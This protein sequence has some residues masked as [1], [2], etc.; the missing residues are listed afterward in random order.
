MVGFLNLALGISSKEW[1]GYFLYIGRYSLHS[2][3][4]EDMPYF[5]DEKNVQVFIPRL[6]A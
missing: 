1:V 6:T 4:L 5:H 3:M 2:T